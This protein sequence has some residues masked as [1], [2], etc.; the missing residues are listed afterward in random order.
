MNN[1]GLTSF[2]VPLVMVEKS[3]ENVLN[4]ELLA[5][6]WPSF[7]HDIQTREALWFIVHACSRLC[8]HA[9]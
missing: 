4:L 2:Q 9:S 1:T 7:M 6:Y 5:A 8:A 3:G